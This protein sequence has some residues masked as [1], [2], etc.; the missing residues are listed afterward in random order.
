MNRA[1]ISAQPRNAHEEPGAAA[2]LWSRGA[3]NVSTLATLA[4]ARTATGTKARMRMRRS[5]RP[6]PGSASAEP[7]RRLGVGLSGRHLRREE[8]AAEQQRRV[9][10]AGEHRPGD[11]DV[12]RD[13]TASGSLPA[14]LGLDPAVPRVEYDHEVRISDD[15]LGRQ[16]P[17]RLFGA[18]LAAPDG[19]A[20]PGTVQSIDLTGMIVAC[21]AGAVRVLNIQPAGKKRLAPADWARGR[22]IAEGD[23]FDAAE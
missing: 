1:A 23:R 16:P 8:P 4:R 3:K 11:R 5:I 14:P 19:P 20:E 2:A 6:S 12:A 10:G 21:G 15:F 18:R 22:G 17:G 13:D 9:G 7:L